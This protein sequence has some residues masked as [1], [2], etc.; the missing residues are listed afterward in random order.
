MALA[1]QRNSS[2]R[3]IEPAGAAFGLATP[4]EHNIP[5][6]PSCG[7]PTQ[8]GNRWLLDWTVNLST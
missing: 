1:Q 5:D 2:L 7:A 8:E 3:V 6:R 4:A